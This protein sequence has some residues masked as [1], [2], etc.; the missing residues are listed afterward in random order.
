MAQ[1][2]AGLSPQR[3][4]ESQATPYGIWVDRVAVGQVVAR[5][6]L[7]SHPVSFNQCSVL[8]DSSVAEEV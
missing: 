4:V 5:V 1:A 3:R 6:L 2:V 7:Y 8:I